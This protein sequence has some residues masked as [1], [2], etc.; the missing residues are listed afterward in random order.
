[1][2]DV[3]IIGSG[4]AGLGAALYLQR[5]GYHILVLEE[6]YEGAGQIAKSTFVDNYLGMP[7]IVGYGLGEKF[8]N[9]VLETGV[10]IQEEE[11]LA[12]KH[13][14]NWKIVL[15]GE[16]E[17]ETKAV[18]YAAGAI[19]KKLGVKGEK[20]YTGRG[21]SYCAYCDGTLY[22]NK[23]AA[24]VGGGDTALDDALYLS[25]I[26]EKV[27]L[28]H[29][30]DQFRGAASTVGKIQKRKNIEIL[31]NTEV[32]E[33]S[34]ERKAEQISLSDGRKLDINGL[35]I[36]IGSVPANELVKQYVS[37]DK[38]GYI[39]AAEDGITDCPGLFAA[40]DVRAKKLRQVITAVA[41]G[42]NAAASA[43]GWLSDRSEQE[44]G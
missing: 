27:Y 32:T 19:P 1:M 7:G 18:I 43:A 6:E 21:I 40:G 30:R 3:T 28:I 22:R 29:R 5:A 15:S 13:E 26:C 31:M 36:A 4:P 35:F 11:V 16:K 2:Y 17:A 38:D 33:V 10:S 12:L 37:L 25:N 44:E 34:G 14:K 41:D 20:E 24:V 8:R 39:C 42:A 9:H 23:T